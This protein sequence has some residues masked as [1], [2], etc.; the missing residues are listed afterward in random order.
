[1]RK[2]VLFRRICATGEDRLG[3]DPEA[4]GQTL[5]EARAAIPGMA[6]DESPRMDDLKERD[7]YSIRARFGRKGSVHPAAK[8]PHG[9]PKDRSGHFFDAERDAV[10]PLPCR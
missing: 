7:A 8:D 1:M 9:A 3:G 5:A 2:G 4:L 6:I 10:H